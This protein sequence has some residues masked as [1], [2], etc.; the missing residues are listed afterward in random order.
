MSEAALKEDLNDIDMELESES[1]KFSYL[2]FRV[3]DQKYATPLVEVREV[4]EYIEPNP[5]PNMRDHF[6]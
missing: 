6:L 3:G 5:I 2:I 4:I 1:E